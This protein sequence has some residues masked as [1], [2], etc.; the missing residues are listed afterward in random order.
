VQENNESCVRCH[1]DFPIA[2]EPA[3]WKMGQ[4]RPLS[5]APKKVRDRVS[6]FG[7]LDNL[8]DDIRGKPH[9]CGNCYFDI[10]DALDE[11]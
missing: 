11:G 2:V 9:L 1:E 5:K 6:G 10:L 4:M 3:I 7:F 8:D